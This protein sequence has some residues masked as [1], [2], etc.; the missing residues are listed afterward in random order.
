MDSHEVKIHDAVAFGEIIKDWAIN[1]G[2]VPRTIGQFRQMVSGAVVELGEGFEN[3]EEITFFDAPPR[4]NLNIVLPAV[5]DLTDETPV[6]YPL[7]PFYSELA[8]DGRDPNITDID[9]FRSARIAD[10]VM[11]KCV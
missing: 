11:R 10:Y 6:N 7:H 4:G 2:S 9:A 3:H 1:R 5:S 8:F